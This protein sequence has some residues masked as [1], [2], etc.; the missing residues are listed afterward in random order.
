MGVVELRLRGDT[1]DEIAEAVSAMMFERL[2]RGSPDPEFERYVEGFDYPDHG[3]QA[4]RAVLKGGLPHKNLLMLYR[5]SW[6]S[7]R[8][9]R[10]WAAVNDLCQGQILERMR[11][12]KGREGRDYQG[13]KVLQLT[14]RVRSCR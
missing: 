14:R 5:L 12:S 10:T 7:D 9:D 13:W 1:I 2:R 6:D 8:S 11:P 4:L 3:K